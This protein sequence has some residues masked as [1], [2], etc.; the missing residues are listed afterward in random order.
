MKAKLIRYERLVN[1][2]NFTHE[3]YGIDVELD[4]GES[5]DEGI[6]AAKAFVDRQIHQPNS[7]ERA[8]AMSVIQFDNEEPPF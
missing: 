1:T 8:I 6:I 5:A 3:K 7:Q 2:G 4:K